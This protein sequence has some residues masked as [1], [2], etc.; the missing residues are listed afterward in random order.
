MLKISEQI[1]NDFSQYLES[2]SSKKERLFSSSFVNRSFK[3]EIT[4]IVKTKIDTLIQSV[5][6]FG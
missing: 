4:C 2:S 1:L 6:F 5:F 3:L